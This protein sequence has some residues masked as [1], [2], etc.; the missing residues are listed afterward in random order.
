MSYTM[1]LGCIL[2]DLF[3]HF[4]IYVIFILVFYIIFIIV[5]FLFGSNP[6]GYIGVTCVTNSYEIA[7]LMIKLTLNTY[8][9]EHSK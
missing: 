8:I 1:Y 2:S 6:F 3:V 5:F 7:T 4:Y 9:L